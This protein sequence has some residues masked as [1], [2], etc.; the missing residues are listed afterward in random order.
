MSNVSNAV[1]TE[2]RQ[3]ALKDVHFSDYC[4]AE[5]IGSYKP[6]HRNFKYIQALLGKE[7]NISAKHLLHCAHGVVSDQIPA[8]ELSIDH[9]WVERGINNWGQHSAKNMTRQWIV[10]DLKGLSAE[11]EKAFLQA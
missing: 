5:D 9:V 3:N 10:N 7:Y 2:L 6:H 11:V 1:A 8:E 4:T